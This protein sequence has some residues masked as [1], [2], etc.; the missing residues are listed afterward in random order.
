[1]ILKKKAKVTINKIIIII[2]IIPPS[3]IFSIWDNAYTGNATTME[4][5]IKIVTVSSRKEMQAFVRLPHAIREETSC[6]VPPIWMDEKKAYGSS[7]P[8]LKNSGFELFLAVDVCCPLAG[9]AC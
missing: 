6:Y 4:Q 1:M 5:A 2:S 9:C 7:S 3:G 8:I